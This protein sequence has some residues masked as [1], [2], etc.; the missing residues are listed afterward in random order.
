MRRGL[1]HETQGVLIPAVVPVWRP[2]GEVELS[3]EQLTQE[4]L[5]DLKRVPLA[6]LATSEYR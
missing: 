1:P 6:R 4:P 3:I 5:T 2:V